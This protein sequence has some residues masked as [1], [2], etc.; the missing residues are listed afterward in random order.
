MANLPSQLLMEDQ[1]ELD[2]LKSELLEA[3]D[4]FQTY[5]ADLANVDP[6]D[7]AKLII[8]T[9]NFKTSK[10]KVENLRRDTRVLLKVRRTRATAYLAQQQAAPPAPATQAAQVRAAP[11][12]HEDVKVPDPSPFRG[13]L[14]DYSRFAF[15]VTNVIQIRTSMNTDSKKI[16]YIGTLMKDTALIWHRM[17]VEAHPANLVLNG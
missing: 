11:T 13:S 14:K 7:Q 4:E 8:A 6:T 12:T 1:L 2:L 10:T 5:K 3:E 15:E 16:T 17:W 9:T